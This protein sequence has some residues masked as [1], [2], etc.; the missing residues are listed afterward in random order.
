MAI[1]ETKSAPTDSYNI[2]ESFT[3]VDISTGF[4]VSPTWLF[5]QMILVCGVVDYYEATLRLIGSIRGQQQ[6]S[7]NISCML[8]FCGFIAINNVASYCAVLPKDP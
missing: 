4:S 6:H 1:S 2:P 5:C 8:L 7:V 3:T